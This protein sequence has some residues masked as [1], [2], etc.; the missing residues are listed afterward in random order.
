MNV[1]ECLALSERAL[2]NLLCFVLLVL[3]P[4][5]IVCLTV[6]NG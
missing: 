6:V 1:L 5:H 3:G 2:L 4:A